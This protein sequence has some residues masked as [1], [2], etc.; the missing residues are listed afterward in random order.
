MTFRAKPVVKRAH[1]P[2]WEAQDRRNFYLNLGFGLIVLIAVLILIAAAGF[3]YYNDHLASVGSVDGQSITKDDLRE[4]VAIEDWRLKES[5]SRV[6][7]AV[8]AGHLTEA[9]ASAAQQT[10]DQQRAS[11]EAIA[12]ERI[13]DTRLQ[14]RLAT[15]EGVSAS[16]ADVDARMLVEATTPESRHIWQIEVEPETTAGAVDPTEAQVTAARQKA[17]AALKD[18]QA[19]KA[20]EDVAKTVSTDTATAPQAGDLGFLAAD[21]SLTDE[22]LLKAVFAAAPNTP[23][24]VIEGEDGIFRIG[25]VT[26]IVP[27]VVDDAYQA[28]IQNDRIDLAKYRAVVA[29]DVIHEKLTEK[30]VGAATAAGPQRKVSEIA[31]TAPGADLAADAVKV[32]HILYSPNGD[33]GTAGD[34]PAN[35]PAW[36]IARAKAL[37]TYNKLK[38]DPKL[39]DSIARA[40]SDETQANGPT[41]SGGKLPYIGT[42]SA[43]DEAFLKAVLTPGLNEGDLIEPVKTA[44]GWHVIQVMYRPTDLERLTKIKAQADGGADFGILARDESFAPTAGSGG[45]MGWIAKGQLDD[46][47]TEAIFKA[48]IGGTSEIVDIKDDALYLYK[49]LAEEV[50]TPEGRQLEDLKATAFSDWYDAKKSA[51]TITRA[52]SD[53]PT[54]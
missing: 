13:I 23:T 36:E 51:A 32:R 27:A 49:V 6:R 15:E 17:E 53:A 9:Q 12:L 38:A 34:L 39:F 31:I 1:R 48:P 33:P 10:I 25:R 8:L 47:L 7:T 16:P 4:R 21:D 41:G 44:F 11:I 52:E 2:A 45:D 54:S 43:I 14:A 18:L 5:E 30:I 3:S 37:T 20:W 50:R 22:G 26:E 29:G 35:D 24:A 28:K 40:E 46:Q 42:G 19:G